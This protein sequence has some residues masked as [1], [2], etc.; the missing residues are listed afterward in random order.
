M[1]FWQVYAT[2]KAIHVA[3]QKDNCK[4][5]FIYMYILKKSTKIMKSIISICKILK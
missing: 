2:L 4:I 1:T 5:D 3:S